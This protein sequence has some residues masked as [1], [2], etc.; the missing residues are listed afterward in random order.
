VTEPFL[1]GLIDLHHGD[2]PVAD[3]LD[4][5]ELWASRLIEGIFLDQAPADLAGLGAVT[6][7]VR[8]ARRLGFQQV[9]LN[10]GRPVDPRYRDLDAEICT[11]EGDWTRYQ[12][13]SG[14]GSQPGD[15]HLVY[16]VPPAQQPAAHRLMRLRQA[17][18]AFVTA[19]PS[20]RD[21]G[22]PQVARTA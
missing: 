13:W 10:P 18:L 4:E 21:Q 5:V 14:E 3:V 8:L 15:G 17:G 7:A 12:R 2:R 16:G 1:T 20:L 19:S 22:V 6:L 9:V 11:F